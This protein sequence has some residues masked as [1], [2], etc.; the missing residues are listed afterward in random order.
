MTTSSEGGSQS[1][2]KTLEQIR[3]E[4]RRNV[5]MKK[6]QAKKENPSEESMISERASIQSVK[7]PSK[8]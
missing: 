5:E 4:A 2:M 1:Q 6:K 3:E 8:P 7:P